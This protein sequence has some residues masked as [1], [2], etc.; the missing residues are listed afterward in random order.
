MLRT[1]AIL[2][3]MLTLST[4]AFADLIRADTRKPEYSACRGKKAGSSC[5]FTSGGKKTSG[6]CAMDKKCNV[7]AT[8]QHYY[9]RQMRNYL[10]N[11]RKGQ[12][13]TPP[14]PRCV[15]RMKCSAKHKKPAPKDTPKAEVPKTVETP[16]TAESQPAE[17]QPTPE[18]EPKVE[19]KADPKTD[20]T[21]EPKATSEAAPEAEPA[22]K[23][24]S[25]ASASSPAL[26]VSGTAL[27]GLLLL[28]VVRRRSKRST[29]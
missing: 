15:S 19:P 9:K 3:F 24:S 22:P 13:P 29:S 11:G 10:K 1:L 25:C 18:T 5:S 8:A 2:G 6:A 28:G 16:K 20:P 23:A 21:A 7:N 27:A 12:M 17:S 26:P 14:K 4:P